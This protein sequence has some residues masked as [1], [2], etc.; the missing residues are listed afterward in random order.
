[1]G[2]V[3]KRRRPRNYVFRLLD[4]ERLQR[5]RAAIVDARA[6]ERASAPAAKPSARAC[7]AFRNLEAAEG[8]LLNLQE[9]RR[10]LLG[11]LL[12]AEEAAERKRQ[13]NGGSTRGASTGE[14]MLQPPTGARVRPAA[15][16]AM[17]SVS[18]PTG[19]PGTSADGRSEEGAVVRGLARGPGERTRND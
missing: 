12:H 2:P 10:R 14:G 8:R 6:H 5:F 3:P 19:A 15:S 1:M 13:S 16:P 4:G 7:A 11:D 17:S 9:R 18:S